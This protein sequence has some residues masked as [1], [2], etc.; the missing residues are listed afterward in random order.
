[1][2]WV[3]RRSS[4]RLFLKYFSNQRRCMKHIILFIILCIGIQLSAQESSAYTPSKSKLPS[5]KTFEERLEANLI[6]DVASLEGTTKNKK[7]IAETYASRSQFIHLSATDADEYI[8]D[9]PLNEYVDGI[10]QVILD[11]NPNLDQERMELYVSRD[12]SPNASCFGEGTLVINSSLIRRLENESQVAFVIAHEIAHYVDNHVNNKIINY[13]TTKNSKATQKEIKRITKEKYNRNKQ[14]AELLK[15]VVYD[16]SKHS[17]LNESEAD[18]RALALLSNTKYS[19]D[20]APK[21]LALLDTIDDEKYEEEI[22]IHREFNRELYPFKPEWKVEENPL[23]AFF[24]KDKSLELYDLNADSLKTHPDCLQRASVIQDKISDY[25]NNDRNIYIQS[26][27]LHDEAVMQADFDLVLNAYHYKHYGYTIYQSLQLQQK[28][29]EHPFL[30]GIIGACM[31]EMAQAINKHELGK[32][33]SASSPQNEENYNDLLKFLN[34]LTL[35]EMKEVG[36][37]Y[38]AIYQDRAEE[39]EALA[40]GLAITA[41]LEGKNELKAKYK[42][43]Y[44]SKF[45]SGY[46]VKKARKV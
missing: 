33:L 8:F 22:I 32:V 45:S 12:L 9:T 3:L 35:I 24:N 36:W 19:L 23:E 26:Q 34:N 31:G 11:A 17:R 1:L 40:Y 38:V 43:L 20:E 28:Y 5:K 14:G 13:V 42:S 44:M 2:F 27:E 30:V 25:N 21:A 15:N 4:E 10:F 29:P 7:E 46:F 6:A 18:E 41:K 37:N 39:S 16:S